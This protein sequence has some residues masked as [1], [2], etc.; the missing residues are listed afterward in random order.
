MII[1]NMGCT[2][3]SSTPVSWSKYADRWA[4]IGINL[5]VRYG[6]CFHVGG[7]GCDFHPKDSL[8]QDYI[9][10]FGKCSEVEG[11]TRGAPELGKFSYG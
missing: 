10:F 2:R 3:N 4:G 9:S 7:F 8:V 11:S 6:R 5:V 1:L